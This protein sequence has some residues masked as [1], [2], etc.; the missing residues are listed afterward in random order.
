MSHYI[1]IVLTLDGYFCVAPP[2]VVFE[3]DLVTLPG[4]SNVHEVIC[5][6]TDSVGGEHIQLIEKY[7]GYSLPRIGAKYFK[8]E[9]KWDEPVQE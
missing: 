9:V 5:V 4:D 3:G 2:W 7:A 1:D 8:K 6:A